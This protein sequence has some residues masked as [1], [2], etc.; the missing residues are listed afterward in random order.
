METIRRQ[1]FDYGELVQEGKVDGR[2]YTSPDI[3]EDEIER[4]FHRWWVY[5]GHASEVPKAGDY[6]LTR[7]GRQ[8]IIMSRDE[9]GE[10][11]L[12]MN[13]CRHRGNSVCQYEQGNSSFFRCWYH[14]WTYNNK[15][16]LVGL[17]YPK[18]YD[19]SFRKEDFGLVKVPRVEEY[20][21]FIFGSLAPE[22]ITLGEHLGKAKEVI[23]IFIDQ[24]P[25]G[26]IEV[27]AGC[28][29]GKV[30]G[31]WKLIGMDGYHVE[32]VHRSVVML[33]GGDNGSDG[34]GS[35]KPGTGNFSEKTEVKGLGAKNR[36]GDLGNGHVRL[37]YSGRVTEPERHL[38]PLLEK[39]W[40]RRYLEA[41]EEKH[42]KERAQDLICIKTPHVG[43]WPN[44]QLIDSHIRVMQPVSADETRVMMF[45]TTLKGVPE[46]LNQHRLRKHEW[47][48]GPAGFGSPDDYEIF[49]RNQLG[50]RAQVENTVLL[51]RGLS[52]EQ[53]NTDGA[54]T[55]DFSG[56]VTQR[57]QLR[58]WK[59]VMLQG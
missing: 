14:G 46:E 3:F 7:I 51:S 53:R 16:D 43:I 21:G 4:I 49:E 1:E 28:N 5:V 50:M 39:P 27:R 56:E 19:E 29:K 18:A 6:R 54:R 15:G 52:D 58:R 20:R 9:E 24:S 8:P 11:H 47:F 37:D 10:V 59:E 33:E 12:L 40:G 38:G 41:M 31:N 17:P 23:D 55:N 26:E 44:L 57:G 48:Y 45:P 2:I 32:F 13:R 22:G 35:G 36:T 34:K 42:G 25:V 30:K